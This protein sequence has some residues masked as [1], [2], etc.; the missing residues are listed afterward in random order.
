MGDRLS[1]F[2][3]SYQKLRLPTRR[4]RDGFTM[5]EMVCVLILLGILVGAASGGM[6]FFSFSSELDVE[7][8][9]MIAR[10]AHARNMG[11]L[12]DMDG[13]TENMPCLTVA[14][15]KHVAY[16]NMPPLPGEDITAAFVKGVTASPASLCF[17]G[18]GTTAAEITLTFGSD[19]VVLSIDG[20]G[21]VR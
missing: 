1:F 15:E 6:K 21:F 9:R 12:M 7:K 2:L 20:N 14:D 3:M 5:L 17:S 11:V 16:E 13:K 18:A 10:I 19:S 8:A 4:G